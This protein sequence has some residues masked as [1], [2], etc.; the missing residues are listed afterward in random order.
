MLEMVSTSEQKSTSNY[1]QSLPPSGIPHGST[2]STAI[3]KN[4]FSAYSG[5]RVL[6]FQRHPLFGRQIEV[7]TNALLL[8]LVAQ[9]GT[10]RI[11]YILSSAVFEE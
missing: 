3:S 6:L 1:F 4:L 8:Q 7:Y 2:G 5:T 10:S 9:C 11:S